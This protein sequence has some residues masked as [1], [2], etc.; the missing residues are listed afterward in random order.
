MY[1]GLDTSTTSTGYYVLDKKGEIIK[2]GLITPEG[3]LPDRLH[4]LFRT[5][6]K[7]YK[8]F[9]IKQTAIEGYAY[10]FVGG[11]N[12]FVASGLYQ[13]AEAGGVTPACPPGTF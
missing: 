3:S 12:K 4:Y 8:A 6:L 11:R 9:D 10:G 2:G 7:I 13:T 5:L 1:C